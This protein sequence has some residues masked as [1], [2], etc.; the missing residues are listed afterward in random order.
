MTNIFVARLDYG[1]TQ[2]ELKSAFEQ[3]G[4]VNKASLAIDKETGK[5]KGFAF[6][7][8][9]NDEEAQ[10]AIKSLDGFTMHGREI[11]VKQAESREDNRPKRDFSNNPRKDYTSDRKP[12]S[13]PNDSSMSSDYKKVDPPIAFNPFVSPE[14]LKS[15]GR[16]KEAP[17]SK[18]SEPKPKTHKMEA[19]KK[20]GKKPRFD[21]DDEDDY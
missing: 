20:S 9:E 1:V 8:M 4:Q 6:I 19:Y 15:E 16:K 12:F 3:F 13:R 18:K 10:A 14:N 17:L 2:E 5:S 7:E 21:Y 11:A